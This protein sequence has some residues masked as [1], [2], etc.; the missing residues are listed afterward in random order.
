[1][2][3]AWVTARY[4][5]TVGTPPEGGEDKRG[6]YPSGA[7]HPYDSHVCWVFKSARPSQICA[8]V[9][10]PVTAESQNDGFEFC[11]HF[12][13]LHLSFLHQCRSNLRQNL[14]I[15]EVLHC[16]GSFWTLCGTCAASS[17]KSSNGVRLSFLNVMGAICTDFLAEATANALF[18]VYNRSQRFRFHFLVC[19]KR[20][21]SGSRT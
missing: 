17:A 13:F 20:T 5:H 6:V 18:L 10:T 14:L 19:L 21:R 3:V 4:E 12:G 15:R 1:M 16:Y 9:T 2:A 8:C 11:F 7:H